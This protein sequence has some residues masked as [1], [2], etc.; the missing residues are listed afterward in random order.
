MLT[1][2]LLA[3]PVTVRRV[4]GFLHGF[5]VLKDLDGK[6]LASGDV[7]QIPSGNHITTTLKLHFRDGSV[8]EQTAA[9][10]QRKI[11]QLLSYKEVQKGPAFNKPTVL[12]FDTTS[13]NITIQQTGEDAKVKDITKRLDLPA[14]LANGILPTLVSNIDPNAETV[15]SMLVATPEP[16][17]VKLKISPAGQDS[18][19]VGGAGN[20]AEHYIMKIDIGGVTGAVAKVVGKQPPPIHMWML[21]GNAPI[22]LKSESQLFEDGPIWRMEL[23]SPVWPSSQK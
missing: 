8:Y 13:G 19:S 15:L 10:S 11:F 22:F 4:Q 2:L 6:I 12:S 18:F 16:R 9:Y 20:K 5:V 7:T 21:A 3:D 1:A 17:I 23:A 14:D